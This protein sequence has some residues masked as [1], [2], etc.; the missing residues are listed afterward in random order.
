[1]GTTLN[2]AEREWRTLHLPPFGTVEVDIT[3]QPSGNTLYFTCS[4]EL[5]T[6]QIV[7]L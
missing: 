7:F 1:M 3:A 5:Y 2:V 4:M 6:D